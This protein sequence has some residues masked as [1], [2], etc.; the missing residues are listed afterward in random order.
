MDAIHPK[1]RSSLYPQCIQTAVQTGDW[2]ALEPQKPG[3]SLARVDELLSLLITV[4]LGR[5]R[6]Q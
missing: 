4:R 5:V 3:E 2:K 1:V 6:Q